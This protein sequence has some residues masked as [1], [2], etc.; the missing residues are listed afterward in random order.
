VGD[1]PMPGGGGGGISYPHVI[2]PPIGDIH[3]QCGDKLIWYCQVVTFFSS[4][5]GRMCLKLEIPNVLGSLNSLVMSARCTCLTSFSISLCRS[6][7][8]S[9]S[10]KYS[11]R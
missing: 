3:T 5:G 4:Y 7:D 2:H 11:E 8:L 9:V 1:P 10:V 6:R